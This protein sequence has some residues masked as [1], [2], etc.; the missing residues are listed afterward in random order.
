MH[1]QCAGKTACSTTG[2]MQSC[3][4]TQPRH[5]PAAE[6][7]SALDAEK[8]TYNSASAEAG[9]LASASRSA[10]SRTCGQFRFLWLVR[11]LGSMSERRT[12][13]TPGT[14]HPPL[15][16]PRRAPAPDAA[17]PRALAGPRNPASPAAPPRRHLRPKQPRRP[18][19]RRRRRRWRRRWPG[20]QRALGALTAGPPAAAPPCAGRAARNLTDPRRAD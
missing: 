7:V 15:P 16:G 12:A 14:A 6:A 18:P 3:T 4:S 17:P 10:A 8:H 5:S 11:I 19:R 20:S 1:V 13:A 2:F 9:S